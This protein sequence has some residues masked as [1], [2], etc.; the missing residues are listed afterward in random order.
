MADQVKDQMEQI[1]NQMH[2]AGVLDDQFQQ[3]LQLQDESNPDFVCEVVRLYFEDSGSKIVKMQQLVSTSAPDFNELDQLVHQFKGSSAS[4]GAHAIAQLCVRL[5][6]ACQQFNGAGCQALL[7]EV[8][9]AF[10][11]L[12]S[13]LESFMQLE[14]QHKQL[15]G[16]MMQ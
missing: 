16:A 9:H 13:G 1:L 12:R 8:K 10:V 15:Q 11:V 14:A 5:R 7:E 3:L 6:E 4:L 2:A